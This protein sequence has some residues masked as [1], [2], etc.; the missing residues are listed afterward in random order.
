MTI[1]PRTGVTRSEQCPGCWNV[2]SEISPPHVQPALELL[3]TAHVVGE[4]DYGGKLESKASI[5]NR[6][7]FRTLEEKFADQL[8]ADQ[9]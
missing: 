1:F 3:D 9:I 4:R 5:E 6:M 8:Y 2:D 7:Q